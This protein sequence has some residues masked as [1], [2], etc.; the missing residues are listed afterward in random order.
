[1]DNP[2]VVSKR[3]S[4][5]RAFAIGV[6]ALTLVAH[7]VI[8]GQPARKGGPP[9]SDLSVTTEIQDVDAN[10]QVCTISSDG[11]GMPVPG[12]RIAKFQVLASPAL[13]S[14]GP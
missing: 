6:F 12:C 10:G 7:Q 1:M 11:T 14:G 8:G 13:T 3:S 2:N 4:T 9:P 5:A